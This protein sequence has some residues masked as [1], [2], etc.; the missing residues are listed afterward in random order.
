M[1][2]LAAAGADVLV[3]S[4]ANTVFIEEVLHLH[5]LADC[6]AGVHT[7]P[8]AYEAGTGALRVEPYHSHSC[9]AGCPPNL[10]KPYSAIAYA[11][12]G[13]GDL[14]PCLHLLQGQPPAAVA[15][16]RVFARTS[17]PG[18]QPCR[19]WA[20]LA[21]AELAPAARARVEPWDSPTALAELLA[22]LL[23]CGRL[24]ADRG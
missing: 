21:A 4:D 14:C 5:G 6:V 20:D 7:N 24:P 23:L 12:D 10:C 15:E 16:V 19:L 1:R 18:G 3:V 22:G 13:G 17:Y 8:A 11:G 9:T 2:G